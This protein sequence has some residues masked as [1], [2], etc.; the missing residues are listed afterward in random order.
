MQ[1]L[2]SY[3]QKQGLSIIAEMLYLEKNVLK[4]IEEE[5]GVI[6]GW[7]KEHIER[8]I[9]S[10]ATIQQTSFKSLKFLHCNCYICNCLASFDGTDTSVIAAVSH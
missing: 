3:K 8:D 9:L 2:K 10:A 5:Y 1:I 4:G 6:Q 7:E